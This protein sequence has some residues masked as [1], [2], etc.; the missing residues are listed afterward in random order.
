MLKKIID[1]IAFGAIMIAVPTAILGTGYG[2]VAVTAVM[3]G[4]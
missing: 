3:F 2:I 1:K 4:S